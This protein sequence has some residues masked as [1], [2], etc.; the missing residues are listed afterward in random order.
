MILITCHS[1]N[2]WSN[3]LL[4]IEDLFLYD[5]NLKFESITVWL[6]TLVVVYFGCCKRWLLYTL[7]V[8][9]FVVVYFGCCIL[10]LLC[11]LVVVY[12]VVVYFGCCKLWLL[13]TLVVVYFGCCILW[14]FYT[15]IVLYFGCCILWLLYTLVVVYFDCFILWLF[16]TLVVV[17][18]GLQLQEAVD[19]FRCNLNDVCQL[20]IKLQTGTCVEVSKTNLSKSK[21]GLHDSYF[22]HV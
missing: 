1:Y 12:F 18:F 21:I 13:Y 14:L 2:C 4:F 11:T 19:E 20:L 17:Y 16:Y 22:I 8:V 10:W 6:Y 15:L 3:S 7:V 5:I 9:Y